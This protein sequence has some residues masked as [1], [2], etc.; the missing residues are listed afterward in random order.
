MFEIA[1]PETLRGDVN[2]DGS[3]TVADLVLMQKYLLGDKS[4][5][6]ADWKAGDLCEDDRV[7]VFDF[8]I[9][10]RLII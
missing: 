7:D 4:A 10:R 6:L 9:L 1:P 2:A 8:C 5:E 3:V